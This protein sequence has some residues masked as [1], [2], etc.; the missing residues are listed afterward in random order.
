MPGVRSHG[1]LSGMAAKKKAAPARRK[2]AAAKSAPAMQV[3]FWGVRGSLASPGQGTLKTGGN[4]SCV[5]VSFDGETV[6][7]D[8]GTGLRPLGLALSKTGAVRVN[9]FLSHLRLMKS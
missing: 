6:V 4:T 7:F 2:T 5:E 1:S 9:L 8:L 3:R